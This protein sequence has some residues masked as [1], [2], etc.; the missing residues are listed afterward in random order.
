MRRTLRVVTG[1]DDGEVSSAAMLDPAE[2]VDPGSS[3]SL[4]RLVRQ[5]RGLSAV[6]IIGPAVAFP[7]SL[8]VARWTSPGDFGEAQVVLLAYMYAALFRSGTFEAASRAVVHHR[9]RGEKRDAIHLQNVG[10]TVELGVSLLPGI[11]LFVAAFFTSDPLRIV[12]FLLARS[13]F[14]PRASSRTSAAST[15]RV[16]GLTLCRRVPLFGRSAHPCYFSS[17]CQCSEPERSSSR[18]SWRMRS[19]FWLL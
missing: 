8:L 12:G 9:A 3:L 19:P 5:A 18:R 6:S 1:P 17:A 16:I 10:V 4:R 15:Q 11:A 7:V 13:R 2:P 14:S